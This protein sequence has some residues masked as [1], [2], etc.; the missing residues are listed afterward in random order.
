MSD[1][2]LK[3]CFFCGKDAGKRTRLIDID[4]LEPTKHLECHSDFGGLILT[5]LN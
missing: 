2:E 3:P 5:S 1:M 4:K